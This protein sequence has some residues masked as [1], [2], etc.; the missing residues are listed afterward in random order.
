MR[1]GPADTEDG[2]EQ[3]LPTRATPGIGCLAGSRPGTGMPTSLTPDG[4]P[5]DLFAEV[6][7]VLAE[8]GMHV[9]PA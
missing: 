1:V 5:C 6:L 3:P 8:G 7:D 9:R 2:A 4:P